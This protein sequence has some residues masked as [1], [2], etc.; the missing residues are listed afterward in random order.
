MSKDR[1]NPLRGFGDVMSALTRVQQNWIAHA[2]EEGAGERR[3]ATARVSP[4]DI[5]AAGTDLRI[6]RELAGGRRKA[7]GVSAS[8]GVLTVS[9]EPRRALEARR[10][11]HDAHQRSGGGRPPR[12]AFRVG[13]PRRW[14][15]RRGG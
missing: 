3:H 8:D 15:P 2:D 14:R 10:V 13:V 4:A 1:R 9:G 11:V 6:R 7:L 12:Y 5:L